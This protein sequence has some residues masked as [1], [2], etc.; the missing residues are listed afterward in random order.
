MKKRVKNYFI[1]I[2][3]LAAVVYGMVEY[4]KML[5]DQKDSLPRHLDVRR[6]TYDTTSIYTVVNEGSPVGFVRRVNVAR[7]NDGS[8]FTAF[9]TDSFEVIAGQK[10]RLNVYLFSITDTDR[11]NKFACI[12]EIIR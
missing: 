11:E 10:V 3:I 12:N 4:G 8:I 7:E 9:V 5:F 2:S 6:N 1:I